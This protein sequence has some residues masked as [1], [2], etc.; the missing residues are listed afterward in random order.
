MLKTIIASLIVLALSVSSNAKEV[1]FGPAI[2]G[3]CTGWGEGIKTLFGSHATYEKV[4]NKCS[5]MAFKESL[6]GATLNKCVNTCLIQNKY[7]LKTKL[8]ANTG[9]DIVQLTLDTLNPKDY[10]QEI[11]PG[12]LVLGMERGKSPNELLINNSLSRS[13]LGLKPNVNLTK[14]DKKALL[15]NFYSFYSQDFCSDTSVKKTFEAGFVYRY[16][17]VLDDNELI[18]EFTVGIKDCKK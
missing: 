10:P 1:K 15:N 4:L 17:Y 11:E 7:K 9:A 14:K 6:E 5:E 2:A 12:M 18:G 13:I 3:Q 8:Y 16:N